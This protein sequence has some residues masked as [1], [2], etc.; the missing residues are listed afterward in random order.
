MRK[1]QTDRLREIPPA[2][3][4][5]PM[6]AVKEFEGLSVKEVQRQFFLRDLLHR[7][8]PGRYLYHKSGL[9]APPGSVV[10]FQYS[11]FLV[12]EAR[13]QRSYRFLEPDEDY[14][15]AL[16]FDPK[17]IRVFDKIGSDVVSRIWPEFK[18]FSH[19]KW[20]KLNPK[21]YPV[22]EGK[23]KHVRTPKA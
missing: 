6:S 2:V 14:N 23:L 12:A 15:G 18:G 13:F 9:Q 21:R 11:D 5:L 20:K 10:L 16:Y 7:K 19:V 1:E 3:R 4:I 8:T 17:T 22:F